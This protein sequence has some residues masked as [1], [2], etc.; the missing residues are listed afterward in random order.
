MQNLEIQTLNTEAL[1]EFQRIDRIHQRQQNHPMFNKDEKKVIMRLT[2]MIYNSTGYITNQ[3]KL[4]TVQEVD[5]YIQSSKKK[6]VILL[7]RR[8]G[9]NLFAGNR[10]DITEIIRLTSLSF[11]IL[12]YTNKLCWVTSPEKIKK[13]RFT[14]MQ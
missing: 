3:G 12:R 4:V 11:W 14:Y 9:E 1:S 13:K 7:T 2:A 5:N 8:C 6:S 10:I